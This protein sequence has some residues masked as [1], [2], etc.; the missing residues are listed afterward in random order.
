MKAKPAKKREYLN[1]Q[2]LLKGGEQEGRNFL[3][4]VRDIG[5]AVA[6]VAPHGGTIEPYTDRI[7][8]AIA[9]DDFNCYRFEGVKSQ[10]KDMTLHITSH[11]FD[12]EICLSVVKNCNF[13][14]TV[15]GV[16]KNDEGVEIGGLDCELRDAVREALSRAGFNAKTAKT[17]KRDGRHR[18][19]ICN[20]G[21]SGMGVQLEL[22]MGLRRSL[23][24][25][26][27][28]AF[29]GAIRQAIESRAV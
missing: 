16:D 22:G 29:V 13:V 23:K 10:H 3:R 15:H 5:S 24:G 25:K 19:N 18:A 26:H 12:D 6:I 14:L 1:F 21:R 11:H 27:L 17:G 9:G 7:A 28:G 20:R 2:A 4:C 8:A